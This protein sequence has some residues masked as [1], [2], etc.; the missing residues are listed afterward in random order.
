MSE[1]EPGSLATVKGDWVSYVSNIIK[2][3]GGGGVGNGINKLDS[4]VF[5]RKRISRHKKE[6]QC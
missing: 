5:E 3:G 1:L 2:G 6:R 4:R